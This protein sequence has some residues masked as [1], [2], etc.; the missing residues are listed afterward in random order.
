MV[1]RL[2]AWVHL[3]FLE[4]SRGAQPLFSFGRLSAARLIGY[5]GRCVPLRR[6]AVTLRRERKRGRKAGMHVL[7]SSTVSAAPGGNVV[8]EFPARK[9]S[10]GGG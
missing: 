8:A 9:I 7:R 4:I 10:L 2:W 5:R 1:A 6:A 3:P